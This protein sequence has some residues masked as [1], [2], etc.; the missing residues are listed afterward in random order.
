MYNLDMEKTLPVIDLKLGAKLLNCDEDI[1]KTMIKELAASLPKA[2]ADLKTAYDNQD[3]KVLG[4][5]AHYIHGGTCYCGTP[6]LKEATF[7]LERLAR[8]LHPFPELE[9]AYQ[10]V[11]IEIQSVVEKSASL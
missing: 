10:T 1:A 2:L 3:V 6:R 9:S 7:I 11:R 5:V 8:G 4:N